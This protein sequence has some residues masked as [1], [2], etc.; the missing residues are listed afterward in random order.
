M[1]RRS[2]TPD[3]RLRAIRKAHRELADT[4]REEVS[5]RTIA[6]YALSV[7]QG[8]DP[9]LVKDERTEDGWRVAWKETGEYAPDLDTKLRMLDYITRYRDGLPVQSTVLQ[10]NIKVQGLIVGAGLD[11]STLAGL[12]VA[13][14]AAAMEAV[15]QALLPSVGSTPDDDITNAEIV[16][17]PD[18]GVGDSSYSVVTEQTGER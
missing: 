15:R 10:Q 3:P 6:Q 14:R 11:M 2:P 12:P 5:S 17:Q 9:V 8:H 18:Q 7:M 13:A 1:A 16:N 4:F